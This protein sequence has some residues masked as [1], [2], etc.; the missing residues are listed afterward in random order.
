[1][2]ELTSLQKRYGETTV[3]ADLSLRIDSGEFFVLVGTSGSG[4]STTLKMINRLVEPDSGTVQID[5][6]DIRDLPIESLRRGIGYVIQST[7]LFPHWDVA[8]NIATVPRLLRWP[9]ARIQAR[10]DELLALLQLDADIAKRRPHELSGGQQQRIGVAR[11]LAADPNIVLMDEPF[12][13]LDPLTREALQSE[14]ARVHASTGKTIVF[15]THDMDEA[16]RLGTRIALLDQG[17]LVQCGTPA[18]ILH[19]PANDF[20]RDFIG[21][22]DGSLRR[23]AVVRVADRLRAADDSDAHHQA[24]AIVADATLKEALAAMIEHRCDR[25]AVRTADGRL[26]GVIGFA[27]LLNGRLP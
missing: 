16:L 10:V 8:A 22:A 11:A 15:V 1:M 5:G 3:V 23:L 13:A 24:P 4:K 27:D 19:S 20:V 2:I 17:Q 12:G 18:E 14:I 9:E 7:G 6:R 21:G 25:L 26:V